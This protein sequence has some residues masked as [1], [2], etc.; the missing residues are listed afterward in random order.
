[1]RFFTTVAVTTATIAASVAAHTEFINKYPNTPSHLSNHL[2]PCS[3]DYPIY[4]KR[5]F[6]KGGDE[7]QVIE[8]GEA[9]WHD[10]Y[11]SVNQQG[12]QTFKFH[13][14]AGYESGIL[15]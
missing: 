4:Y 14:G 7:E 13:K 15:Q 9:H 12:G 3:C 11:P 10:W 8:P 5:D 2:T 6:Y 1:M